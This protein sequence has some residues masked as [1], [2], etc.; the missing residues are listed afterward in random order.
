MFRGI[1]SISI[2]AKGRMSLPTRYREAVQIRSG[3]RLVVTVDIRERCLLLYPLPDWEEVQN[4]L[5]DLANVRPQVR[6]VQRMLIGHATDVDLDSN[7]RVLLPQMLRDFADLKKKMVLLGQGPKMEIWS[8]KLWP[9][10]L[11]EWRSPEAI[12]ALD[13]GDDLAELRY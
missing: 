11:D 3:G 8:A 6:Q 12:Q 9:E 1:N 4:R 10:K 2:D 5:N 13:S 7:G